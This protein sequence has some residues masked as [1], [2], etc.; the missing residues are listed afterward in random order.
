MTIPVGPLTTY[1]RTRVVAGVVATGAWGLVTAFESSAWPLVVASVI[2]AFVSFTDLRFGIPSPELVVVTDAVAVFG[3]I[4]WVRPFP[5]AEALALAVVF[6][7]ALVMAAGRWLR[8]I[9]PTATLVVVAG[10][11][12]N[13]IWRDPPAWSDAAVVGNALVALVAVAPMLFWVAAT[14]A[15]AFPSGS[16]VAAAVPDPGEFA[17]TV[18][19]RSR[20]GLV[21][22]DFESRIRFTNEAFAAMLGYDRREML[23]Q[24]LAM[25]MDSETFQRHERALQQ[26]ML[27]R[28]PIDRSNLELVGRHRDGHPVTVLVSLSELKGGGER[29]VLGAVRDVSEIVAL[30]TQLEE[31]LA[32]KDLFV[33]TVSHELR[34][35]L[36]AVVA[37]AEMLRDRTDLSP[38]EREEFLGLIA[39]QSREVSYLVEDLLVAARLDSD[40]LTVSTQP[41]ALRAEILT[42]VSPFAAQ[43]SIEVDHT[44][45]DRAVRADPGRLRQIIRN[46]VGNAVKHGG[47]SISVTADVA[48]G[49][50]HLI[51][52]DDGA[53]IPPEAEQS[54]FEPYRHGDQ[55]SDQPMSM[56]LGL[57]VS[58]RLAELMGGT[59]EYR[60]REDHTE[61]VLVLPLA[62][63]PR[64]LPGAGR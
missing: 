30:R 12:Y 45:V 2:F 27:S 43:R 13:H 36:T 33:A 55:R 42:V 18:V 61:F 11:L 17:H 37:F 46:L 31:L 44:A 64:T 29:L 8:W 48:G 7:S 6:G 54:L 62:D 57:H 32:S 53:G 56:G 19:E 38:E 34:T 5:G 63:E 15:R 14:V 51:V 22:I 41:T 16:L 28:Q 20:E 49:H 50:C 24:S 39:D 60:R 58:R 59:L 40:E 4:L 52:R 3:A 9:L 26:A 25:A 35:P 21:V 1:R 10:A 47:L 23:G